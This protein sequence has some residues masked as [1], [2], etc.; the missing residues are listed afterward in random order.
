MKEPIVVDSTC[1]IGLE[2]IARLE[3]LPALYEPVIAPPAVREEFGSDLPWLRVEAPAGE[4]L[5]KAMQL[6]VDDGESEAIALAL[7]RQWRLLVDD[8][9]AR[10]VY[11]QADGR[12]HHRNGRG[13]GESEAAR[14]D[15]G[16][17]TRA[18][19]PGTSGVLYWRRAQ[20]G[21]VAVGWRMTN[22]VARLFQLRTP[23]TLR[24]P[25]NPEE[26]FASN[27]RTGNHAITLVQP[28]H[29]VTDRVC[30]QQID[31]PRG[32][33]SKAPWSRTGRRAAAIAA[34]RSSTAEE[35]G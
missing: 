26:Y 1:L 7:E 35:L 30:V 6:L 9:Q 8:R 11:S 17:E 12:P 25:G 28:R 4:G 27:Y 23:L 18:G 19:G 13:S 14:V 33:L 32:H 29:Q 3:L 22:L 5:V 20:A 2:R 10:L 21:S 15:T 16:F 31:H 24:Q 34:S